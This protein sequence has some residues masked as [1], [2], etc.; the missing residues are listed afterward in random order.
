[1]NMEAMSDGSISEQVLERSDC[2]I[3]YWLAGPRTDR[4]Q[5]L[6]SLKRISTSAELAHHQLLESYLLTSTHKSNE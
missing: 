2:P 6:S 3:H 4:S 5:P 1:M